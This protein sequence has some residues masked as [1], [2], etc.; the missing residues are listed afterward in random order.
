MPRKSASRWYAAVEAEL[1]SLEEAAAAEAGGVVMSMAAP[2]TATELPGEYTNVSTKKSR[3]RSRIHEVFEEDATGKNY[4]ICQ[5]L[6]SEGG[7]VCGA[8]IK[9]ATGSSA[10]RTH[11]EKKHPS[12]WARLA[13][14]SQDD[15]A[16]AEERLASHAQLTLGVSYQ[17]MID[18]LSRAPAQILS[19]AIESLQQ[20]SEKR[21]RGVS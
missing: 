8:R 3:K 2:V 1:S 9:C 14:D 5:C 19:D 4:S 15:I 13:Q 11:V 12:M 6:K 17:Q 7:D 18:V 21:S 20:V 10:L 16:A